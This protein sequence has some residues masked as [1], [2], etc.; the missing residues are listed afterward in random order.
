MNMQ[1]GDQTFRFIRSRRKC[2]FSYWLRFADPQCAH[3]LSDLKRRDLA[4][5]RVFS[6]ML[7]GLETEPGVV[8]G[9]VFELT[10]GAQVPGFLFDLR[11]PDRIRGVTMVARQCRLRKRSSTATVR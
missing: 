10:D 7:K 9:A 1:I 8:L 5:E 2:F 3:A 11:P 4:S 6:L